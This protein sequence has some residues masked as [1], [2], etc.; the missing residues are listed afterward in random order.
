MIQENAQDG[1]MDKELD[2]MIDKLMQ[3]G[4]ESPQNFLVR[5]LDLRQKV[6]FA[7]QEAG[8]GLKYNPS[9]VQNMFLHALLTGLRSDA[10][11]SEMR[12]Y[13][14][15]P[16]TTDEELFSKMNVAAREEAE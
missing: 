7:S 9:L 4:K 2:A 16:S 8:S 6:I 14:Q 3:E 15:N 13:L 5:A 10:V 12:P 11:K 1:E